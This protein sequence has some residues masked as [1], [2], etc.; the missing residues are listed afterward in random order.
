M[1][2]NSKQLS[3][4]PK[5]MLNKF[6]LAKKSENF[7]IVQ[8]DDNRLDHYYILIQPTGGHYRGQ[9]H[10]LEMKT[11]LGI[12]TLYPFT[13]P[14]IKFVTKIW[15]PNISTSGSICLDILKYTNKWS[16]QYDIDALIASIILLLDCPENS[17]PF[18]AEAA[19][20]FRKCE[21]RNK[22]D[23]NKKM[24]TKLRF[25]LYNKC[26]KEFDDKAKKYANTKIDVYMKYFI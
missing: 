20:L 14:M 16:P 4:W 18:N 5:I 2:F 12:N 17:D 25:E 6:I 24:D 1:S 21:K 8:I 7:K 23:S 10:I 9:T 11:K 15:H 3:K 19:K 26:F 22:I 13:A